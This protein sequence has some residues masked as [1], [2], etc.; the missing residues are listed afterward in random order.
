MKLF[1]DFR[2][3]VLED[4]FSLHVYQ[5]KVSIVNYETIGHFDSNSVRVNI[6]NGEIIVKGK[7]L[8]V[9]KLMQAE[10]LILGTIQ[11]I[12]FR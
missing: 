4:Q 6:Q 10:I 1:D 7:N 11:A 8:V 2:S 12:E 3:F 5:N 9:S